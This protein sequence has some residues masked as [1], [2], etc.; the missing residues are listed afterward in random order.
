SKNHAN[1]A[2][3]GQPTG[4]PKARTNAAQ[5]YLPTKSYPYQKNRLSLEKISPLLSPFFSTPVSLFPFRRG[6]TTR[7]CGEAGPAL[8]VGEGR[9]S[10]PP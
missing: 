4:T 2:S 5:N 9:K 8:V 7:R 1:P 10:L 6:Y 3:C